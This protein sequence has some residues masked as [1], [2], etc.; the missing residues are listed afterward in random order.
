MVIIKK[1]I[2]E[3]Q[4]FLLDWWNSSSSSSRVLLLTINRLLNQHSIRSKQKAPPAFYL[5][6]SLWSLLDCI[7]NIF[8]YFTQYLA[9]SWDTVYFMFF[10]FCFR[11]FFTLPHGLRCWVKGKE[12]QMFNNQ[13]KQGQRWPGIDHSRIDHSI[14]RRSRSGVQYS[15]IYI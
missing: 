9:A 8:L 2:A 5:Y 7:S 14:N 10:P 11:Y 13:E 15:D 6:F 4:N 12:K 3:R 1:R